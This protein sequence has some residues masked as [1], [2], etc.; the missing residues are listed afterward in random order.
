M[1]FFLFDDYK[2]VKVKR[3]LL[4]WAKPSKSK[5]LDPTGQKNM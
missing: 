5:A 3:T 1:G 4:D 2:E